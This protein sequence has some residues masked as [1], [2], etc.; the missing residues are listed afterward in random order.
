MIDPPRRPLLGDAALG[1]ILSLIVWAVVGAAGSLTPTISIDAAGAFSMMPRGQ[2]FATA[3]RSTAHW[4]A[5]GPVLVVATVHAA[6][7][8]RRWY[9]QL[10]A[11]VALA[12]VTFAIVWM[13]G[14]NTPAPRSTVFSRR[15]RIDT[16][17]TAVIPLEPRMRA[18]GFPRPLSSRSRDALWSYA[19]LVLS[20]LLAEAARRRGMAQRAARANAERQRALEAELATA[21]LD[22]LRMELHPHFLYN[23][24]NMISGLL[25]ERPAEAKDAIA[26]LARLLRRTV[27]VETPTVALAEELDWLEDY[28]EL[29]QARFG[30]RLRIDILADGDVRRAAVPFLVLQPL[31]ENAIVH[32]LGGGSG[33][34]DGRIVIDAAASG[35]RLHLT[36]TDN[37]AGLESAKRRDGA[38][39]GLTNIRTRLAVL[40]G[41]NASLAI[42]EAS[43]GGTTVRLDLPA[44]ELPASTRS[45][46]S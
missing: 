37:G 39:I 1:L 3:L 7:M 23:A 46:S 21:K 42:G 34:A 31:V 33:R 4:L 19:L 28:V 36:V 15:T 13:M 26:R 25:D 44:A 38:G 27:G 18:A 43:N 45:R 14:R 41:A 35:G 29:Q 8:Q 20:S 10:A 16:P 40:Y 12:I 32:G 9:I 22:A 6:R 2:V 30:D 24:L 17:G 5:I 11:H